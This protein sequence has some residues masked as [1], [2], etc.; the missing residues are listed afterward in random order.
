TPARFLEEEQGERY[1]AW[2]L[3]GGRVCI[4]GVSDESL[5]FGDRPPGIRFV[6]LAGDHAESSVSRSEVPEP[7]PGMPLPRLSGDYALWEST[8]PVHGKSSCP[9]IAVRQARQGPAG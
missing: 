8:R 7:F 2:E 1:L 3:R 4:K 6:I 9:L 5:G